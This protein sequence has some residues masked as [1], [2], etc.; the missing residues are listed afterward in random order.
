MRLFPGN[1]MQPSTGAD[2]SRT[3][4]CQPRHRLQPAR[5][6]RRRVAARSG[7]SVEAEPVVRS[8]RDRDDEA[9]EEIEP[10][11]VVDGDVVQELE[12]TQVVDGEEAPPAGGE[13]RRGRGL[14]QTRRAVSPWAAKKEPAAAA[15]AQ[16]RPRPRTPRAQAAPSEVALVQRARAVV[17]DAG[18]AALLERQPR[19]LGRHCRDRPGC[20]R[21]T[22]SSRTGRLSGLGPLE[23]R[24]R[25]LRDVLGVARRR[26]CVWL[27]VIVVKS[28]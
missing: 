27:R 12:V 24:D 21:S 5:R 17:T 7:R 4:S 28:E 26:R 18:L 10:S 20:A 19:L 8:P 6:R 1:I 14:A 23:Q 22:P 11:E 3:R 13:P 25:A 2:D 9:M 16:D 15:R